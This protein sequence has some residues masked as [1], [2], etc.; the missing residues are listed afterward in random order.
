[1]K[2]DSICLILEKKDAGGSLCPMKEIYWC[3]QSNW[4]KADQISS[5]TEKKPCSNEKRVSSGGGADGIDLKKLCVCVKDP[6]I[7]VMCARP[8]LRAVHEVEYY[9][10][11]LSWRS[12]PVISLAGLAHDTSS[13]FS[14]FAL[15]LKVNSSTL[16]T[17]DIA[18][19]T[20][21][22]SFTWWGLTSELLALK[23]AAML[24]IQTK[25]CIL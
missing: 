2:S 13:T 23:T 4:D 24:N 3:V 18:V 8:S 6:C 14:P 17:L 16:N 20:L 15:L 25:Q 21:W 7:S 10:Q 22:W 1:M 9:F 11:S 5:L 12:H 19:K